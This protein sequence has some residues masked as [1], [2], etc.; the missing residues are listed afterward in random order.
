M[1]K[2]NLRK[3]KTFE[4]NTPQNNWRERFREKFGRF[5]IGFEDGK[6]IVFD[7]EPFS[8]EPIGSDSIEFFISQL[9]EEQKTQVEQESYERGL[10][11]NQISYEAGYVE[12]YEKGFQAGHAKERWLKEK[13]EADV[14][15]ATLAEV[16]AKV[17][18]LEKAFPSQLD[19]ILKILK[20]FLLAKE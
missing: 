19:T 9:L 5:Y 18:E 20:D 8:R 6:G 4:M 14:R 12:A 3:P 17:S 1:E 15:S 13:V 2:T 16:R 10:K 7:R 11:D